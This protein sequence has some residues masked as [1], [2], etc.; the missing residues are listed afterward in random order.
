M[1]QINPN[2]A[3]LTVFE[4][5]VPILLTLVMVSLMALFVFALSSSGLYPVSWLDVAKVT[6]I[7]AAGLA[8][9]VWDFKPADLAPKQDVLCDQSQVV[10]SN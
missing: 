3:R 2:A 8:I 7:G 9:L 6:G 10:D 4:V 5:V 1:F